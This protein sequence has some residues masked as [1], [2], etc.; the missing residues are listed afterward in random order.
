[1][2]LGGMAV[3]MHPR[4]FLELA[5]MADAGRDALMRIVSGSEAAADTGAR[6]AGL[7]AEAAGGGRVH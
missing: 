1:M 4:A 3:Q 2:I 6:S 7:L 5:A